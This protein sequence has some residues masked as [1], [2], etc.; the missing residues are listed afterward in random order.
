M[1]TAIINVCEAF[2]P[3]EQAAEEARKGWI[4]RSVTLDL[5]YD[6]IPGLRDAELETKNYI[7]DKLHKIVK[8][9][10]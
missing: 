1:K 7:Y 5:M 10:I 8:A 9:L 4:S 2:A 3:N 6:N